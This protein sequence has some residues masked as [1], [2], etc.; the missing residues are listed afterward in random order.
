MAVGS[1]IASAHAESAKPAFAAN[2]AGVIA[3]PSGYGKIETVER[4]KKDIAAKG[5]LYF[6][7]VDQA[8]TSAAQA[9]ASRKEISTVPVREARCGS[10]CMIGASLGRK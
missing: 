3:V 8:G 1:P 5:I 7:E 9:T 2:A 10:S 6:G 4:L